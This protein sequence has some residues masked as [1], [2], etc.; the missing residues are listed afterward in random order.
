VKVS[1]PAK[2]TLFL[3]VGARTANGLHELRSV[4]QS[5]SLA[6]EISIEQADAFSLVVEPP[7]AAPGDATNLVAR[8]AHAITASLGAESSYGIVLDKKIP[9]AAGLGGGSSDAAATLVGLN[10]M[11]GRRLSRKALE[12]MAATLGSDVPFCVRGGTAI[13][14][15]TGNLVVSLPAAGGTWWV[16]GIADRSLATADVYAAFDRMGGGAIADPHPVA[17]A[18]ARGSIDTLAGSLRNDLE[19]AALSLMP[20]LADGRVALERAGARAVTLC[21]SGP[22]WAALAGDEE[23]ARAIASVCGDTFA[24]V[25]VAR[26]IQRGPRVL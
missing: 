3:S 24:R 8:A 10:E 7:E 25:E 9:T 22:T 1:A 4:M 6:D 2:L 19:P 18:L 26:S 14:E 5:V 21:G 12:K 15:G 20:S 11:L 17:D 16:L 23:E 13:V